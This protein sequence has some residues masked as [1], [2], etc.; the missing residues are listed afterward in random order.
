MMKIPKILIAYIITVWPIIM[1]FLFTI[2]T[3][4]ICVSYHGFALDDN[5]NIYLGKGSNIEVL[6]HKG[7]VLRNISSYTSRGYKFTIAADNTIRISTGD[8]LYKTDLL[9]NLINK[10]V[11]SDYTE[12]ELVGINGHEFTTPDGTVYVMKNFI[13]R[14]YIY[15]L[16]ET[17][18]IVIYKMPV[19]DYIIKLLA[20]ICF[21]SIIIVVPICII[22]YRKLIKTI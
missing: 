18:N 17:K 11:I 5:A 6:N 3:G 4:K 19:F 2:V 13:L 12:D 7:E 8:Y 10:K 16:E 9:G 14:T 22:K 1:I 20:F 15:R 21:I